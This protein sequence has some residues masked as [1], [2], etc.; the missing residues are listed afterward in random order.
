MQMKKQMIALGIL[1]AVLIGALIAY[2]SLD[3]SP[4]SEAEEVDEQVYALGGIP[5]R[6]V[7]TVEVEGE[8]GSFTLRNLSESLEQEEMAAE[9]DFAVDGMEKEY[10]N[11]PVTQSIAALCGSLPAS[12][13]VEVAEGGLADFGLD[14]PRATAD[15]TYEDGTARLLIGDEAPGG[16]E[17]YVLSGETVY[18]VGSSRVSPLLGGPLELVKKSFTPSSM[19]LNTFTKAVVTGP[20]LPS[21]LTLEGDETGHRIASEDNQTADAGAVSLLRGAFGLSALQVLAE[22]PDGSEYGL[23][24]P[25]ATLEITGDDP[26][27]G[28]VRLR[29]SQPDENGNLCVAAGDSPYVYLLTADSFPWLEYGVFDYLE[30]WILM[31][32]LSTL[33]GVALRVD[34]RDHTFAL[35]GEG[36]EMTVE[37][38][39]K[40]LD[41]ER[42]RA[43][44]GTLVSARY[45]S[46]GES[47]GSEA[48]ESET[49]ASETDESAPEEPA[50]EEPAAEEP[51][52]AAQPHLQM[53]YQYR[54]GSPSDEIAFYPGPA[55]RYL[56]SRNGGTAYLTTSLYV[57]QVEAELAELLGSA[58]ESGSQP[59]Q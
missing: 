58:D 38:D 1:M 31:P 29:I 36:E 6:F 25:Y 42:F 17:T 30:K 24:E 59:T 51:A 2:L 20:K 26:E 40:P 49:E 46:E 11:G 5:R 16:A 27:V 52:S 57:D 3:S 10:V 9:P 7:K 15:I 56:A 43:F 48:E 41:V 18:L 33:S 53:T 45:E 54:D 47:E 44:Y 37:L 8:N 13:T 23:A 14:A 22:D 32:E 4:A 28:T 55:R 35:T 21:P 34:G 12:R 50:V 39:G 19:S